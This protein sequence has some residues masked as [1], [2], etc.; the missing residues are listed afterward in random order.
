MIHDVVIAEYLDGYRFRVTFDNGREGIIDFTSCLD[1]GGVFERFRDI[2]FFRT[3]SVDREIGVLSWG[4]E[5]D[6]APET[7]Y[8]RATTE[9]PLQSFSR[10]ESTLLLSQRH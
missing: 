8:S 6:I 7:L 5:I 2:D 1:A 4:D 10:H 3:F 9:P